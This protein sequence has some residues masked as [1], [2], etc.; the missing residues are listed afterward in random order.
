MRI[1]DRLSALLSCPVFTGVNSSG[2]HKNEGLWVLCAVCAWEDVALGSDV[3]RA[4]VIWGFLY[5]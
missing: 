3:W 2:G 1:G 5:L 4:E